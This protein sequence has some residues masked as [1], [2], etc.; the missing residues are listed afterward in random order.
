VEDAEGSDWVT[1]MRVCTTCGR[2]NAR[3]CIL[4]KKC[5][6]K[7]N[8]RGGRRQER[9]G[10]K[11]GER[12]EKSIQTSLLMESS[13]L[14]DSSMRISDKNERRSERSSNASLEFG[15]AVTILVIVLVFCRF[16][17]LC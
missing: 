13:F 8:E 17:C 4:N 15:L 10:E 7:R 5:V 2:I 14:E 16:L 12:S 1:L 3:Y 11:R 6:R 9:S